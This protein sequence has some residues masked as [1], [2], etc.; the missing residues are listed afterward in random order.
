[1][2]NQMLETSWQADASYQADPAILPA[3]QPIS[4]SA[5]R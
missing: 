5:K 2:V 4:S 3:D 1:M